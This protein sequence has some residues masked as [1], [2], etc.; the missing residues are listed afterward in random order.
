MSLLLKLLICAIGAALGAIAGFIIGLSIGAFVGGNFLQDFVFNSVRGYEAV[1]QIGAIL[2]VL[3][4]SG[5]GILL[6]F[7]K[8]LRMLGG[9]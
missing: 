3:L 4:G 8:C 7:K 2:G 5:C 9:L 6:V 1:G